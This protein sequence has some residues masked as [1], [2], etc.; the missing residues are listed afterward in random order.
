M[1]VVPHVRPLWEEVGNLGGEVIIDGI[2]S[3]ASRPGRD[4]F[5]RRSPGLEVRGFHLKRGR[6]APRKYF[7]YEEPKGSAPTTGPYFFSWDITIPKG[8]IL[9]TTPSIL[10]FRS[11]STCCLP[12]PLTTIASRLR[13]FFHRA[14]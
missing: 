2:R 7:Q 4:R 12:S 1:A 10:T 3:A 13:C 8:E 11:H 5:R 14:M 9:Y 6:L